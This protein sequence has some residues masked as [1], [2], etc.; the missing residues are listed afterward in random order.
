MPAN[1]VAASPAE[2]TMTDSAWLRFWSHRGVL[3]LTVLLG[4]LAVPTLA[5]LFTR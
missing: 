5:L 3:E 1:R 4:L 2:E